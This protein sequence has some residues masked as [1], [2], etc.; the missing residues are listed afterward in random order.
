MYALIPLQLCG[1]AAS[2]R[3]Q[4]YQLPPWLHL[5]K[6]LPVLQV[7]A[8]CVAVHGA[9]AQSVGTRR[10]IILLHALSQLLLTP[11]KGWLAWPQLLSLAMVCA[12]AGGRPANTYNTGHPKT[13][14]QHL[15]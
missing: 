7:P 12:G 8:A 9:H 13:R 14:Q 11:H 2:E 6:H 10:H 4:H 15:Y 3:A 1:D 5:D